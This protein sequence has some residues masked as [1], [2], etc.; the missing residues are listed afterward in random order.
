M[1]SPQQRIAGLLA[2]A[3]LHSTEVDHTT[4]AWQHWGG[5]GTPLLLVHGGFG[6]WT[7]WAAN[8]EALRQSRNVWTLDLPGL[9]SSA[10][11]PK[12]W[13]TEHFAELVL[14]GW[15]QLLGDTEFELAA[16]SF[17]AMIAGHVA[18]LAGPQCQRCCLIGASGFG[19]LHKQVSL[20]P[21]P[22]P[23]V[24]AIE[25]DPIH[26]E[27]LAR[28]MLYRKEAVDDLAVC[29]HSDNLA[30]HRF[31][32]RAM[33]GSNDLADVLPAINAHLVGIWGVHDATAGGIEQ[34][35]ARRA[36]MLASQPEAEFHIL[37][38]IGH[39]AMYESPETVN[40]LI[41]GQLS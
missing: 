29:I 34:I 7:H 40:R 16:F 1:L 14:A 24:P 38:D 9:G 10:D 30:R 11:M 39:W 27:N 15:R 23:E 41:L 2:R 5:E 28:L 37:E 19:P 6:S 8:I 17:G 36:L 32:S 31:R 12:P 21:P 18:A 4:I 33:A 22:G 25:A 20:L 13:T 35:Q 26:R 3:A